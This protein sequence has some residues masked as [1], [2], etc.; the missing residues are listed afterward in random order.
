MGKTT[1]D[2][3]VALPLIREC[4]R[5]C[6]FR[7]GRIHQNEIKMDHRTANYTVDI[8]DN[9]IPTPLLSM[10]ALMDELNACFSTDV[11]VLRCWQTRSGTLRA[12]IVTTN[13][14]E[15]AEVGPT[16]WMTWYTKE[17]MLDVLEKMALDVDETDWL[18]EGTENE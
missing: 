10:A 16:M 3:P 18:L 14:P 15:L 9:P 13:D 1:L 7:L 8:L 4:A 5:Q 6:G 2:H 11:Q 17:Q 12:E